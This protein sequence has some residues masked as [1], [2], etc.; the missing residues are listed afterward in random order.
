MKKVETDDPRY[1]ALI[2]VI[3]LLA[4]RDGPIQEFKDKVEAMAHQYDKEDDHT[5][6]DQAP[7]VEMISRYL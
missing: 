5:F 7:W 1:I 4:E 2:S 6:K 3:A